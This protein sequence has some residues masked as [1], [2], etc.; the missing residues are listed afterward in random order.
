MCTDF[1]LPHEGN[2]PFISGRTLDFAPGWVSYIAKVPAGS[3][4]TSSAPPWPKGKGKGY[5]WTNEYGFVAVYMEDMSQGGGG[6][7]P[8]SDGTLDNVNQTYWD[9]MNTAGLSVGALWLGYTEYESTADQDSSKCMNVLDVVGYILGTCATVDDVQSNLD[10]VVVW[11]QKELSLIRPV[12]LSVH[13]GQ[14]KSLVVEFI[15][16]QKVYYDNNEIAVLTND[17]QFDWHVIQFNATMNALSYQDNSQDRNVNFKKGD[18]GRY[19]T[20]IAP[21]VQSEVLASGMF[22]LPGSAAS[23]SR[24]IRAGKLRQ[25]VPTSFD[26]LTGLQYAIQVLGR[27]AVCEQEVYTYYGWDGKPNPFP[28]PPDSVNYDLTLWS[29]VRDHTNLSLYYFTHLDHTVQ[30]YKL[31]D[32]NFTAGTTPRQQPMASKLPPYVDLTAK[33]KV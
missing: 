3:S 12:H 5:S 29:T 15:N 4:F 27:V 19:Q 26:A 13:D 18:N 22:G 17:P 1:L 20:Y 33:L 14:G 30:G 23:P 25:C 24:F 21:P 10:E 2:S 7:A 8:P 6:T 32:L 28:P 16:G 11:V 31:N 9:G